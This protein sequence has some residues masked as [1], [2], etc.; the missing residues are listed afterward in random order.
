MFWYSNNA[1]KKRIFRVTS[2]YS[3]IELM[4]AV[5]VFAIAVSI[6]TT[7]FVTGLRGQ[8]KAFSNQDLAD[9]IRY[10][11][12]IMTREIRMG[13]GFTSASC[14]GTSCSFTSS[15]PHR[16]GK[17]VT[18]YYDSANER[19]M[20]DDDTNS[21]PAADP[22]TSANVKVTYLNFTLSEDPD[23]GGEPY[24]VTIVLK[25]E[26]ATDSASNITLQTTIAPRVL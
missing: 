15:M 25:A 21:A 20:F 19:I 3:L 8:K 5:G 4:V 26:S 1:L 18:F 13:T 24:R 16:A 23:K 9:N 10:A 11:M 2:G 7:L 6:G 17:M 22:I 14:N 12:E